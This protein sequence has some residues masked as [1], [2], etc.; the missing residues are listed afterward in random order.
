MASPAWLLLSPITAARA[1][2][3]PATPPPDRTRRP[4]PVAAGVPVAL[5]VAAGLWSQGY[6][7]VGR[8]VAAAT[9]GL[10]FALARCHFGRGCCGWMSATRRSVWTRWRW[11]GDGS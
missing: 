2:R 7:D 5:G 6:E 1:R 11:G 9:V 10:P 4:E 8:Y 3:A